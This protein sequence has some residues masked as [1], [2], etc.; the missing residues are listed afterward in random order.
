[1]QAQLLALSKAIEIPDAVMYGIANQ[2]WAVFGAGA[3]LFDQTL[4]QVA[5]AV[6]QAVD[7]YV[8]DKIHPMSKKL[9]L[10][11]ATNVAFA[12]VLYLIVIA[13]LYPIG[14]IIG[15]RTIKAFSTLH[16]LFL[17][18]LSL[19][20]WGGILVT[21]AANGFTLWNNA[22]GTGDNSWRM[23]KLIW[24][25]YVSKLPEF[26]DTII[27]MLKHN[28]RQVSFLHLYHHG[29][30]FVIWFLVTLEGPGGDAYF[31]AMLNSGVHV[32]MYGYYFGTAVFAQGP[33]RRF[34]NSIK[35]FITYGQMAQFATN[36]VQSAYL[37]LV[38]KEAAYPKHLIQLLLVYM[39]TL[40]GLFGNFLIQNKFAAKK[41]KA[42]KKAVKKD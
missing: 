13:L 29:T 38:V 37:L 17:F 40:L 39:F 35:F 36:C 15:K 16:N 7:T 11:N 41:A 21:A 19:Y 30:I 31:S 20:M 32:V 26:I 14:Q 4:R 5:P 28:Y 1:M 23:A 18:L 25:F 42:E 34:L 27:M 12:S 2:T 8:D 33:I 3:T 9:P 6:V 24:I 10:M 22:V